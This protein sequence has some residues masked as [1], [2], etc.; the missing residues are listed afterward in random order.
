M[1]KELVIIG[2]G[3]AGL[4]AAFAAAKD[5]AHVTVVSNESEHYPRCPLPHLIAG[6]YKKSDLSKPLDDMFKGTSVVIKKGQ[7]LKLKDISLECDFGELSYDAAIIASGASPKRIADSLVL[8]TMDDA[9]EIKRRIDAGERGLIIGAGMIGCE[10]ADAIDGTIIEKENRILPRFDPEFS[11]EV[12][13]RLS[14]RCKIL[15]STT[16]APK[17]DF[18]VSAIGVSPNTTLAKDS[19][20]KVSDFGIEVDSC[21]KTSKENVYAAG[22]CVAEKCFITGARIHS[23]YGPQSERQ[24]VIAAKNALDEKC[25]NGCF[26]YPGSLN[27]IVAKIADIEIG[28]AGISSERA[29]EAGIDFTFGKISTTSLPYYSPFGKKIVVKML[30]ERE[31]ERLIGCQAM[32]ERIDGIIN[33]AAYAMMKSASVNELMN[34]P[35]CFSPPVCSAPNPIIICAENA[36]RRL[37]TKIC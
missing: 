13:K 8:R 20:I 24:G 10:L 12:E 25:D 28:M 2:C 36:K 32:G 23:Y 3:D 21:L 26:R 9:L 35:Y 4:S 11:K 7:V 37:K 14:L 30:F 31:T 17:S 18:T 19:G 22:D 15:T 6:E 27:S 33:L 29:K 5:G 34:L 1:P 16:D